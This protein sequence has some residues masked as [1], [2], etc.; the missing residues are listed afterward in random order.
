MYRK[1]TIL[2]AVAAV[3]AVSSYLYLREVPPAPQRE[4]LR[5]SQNV[6]REDK[7][8][9]SDQEA[10]EENINGYDLENDLRITETI[11]ADEENRIESLS[12]QQQYQLLGNISP[13]KM[14]TVL[15]EYKTTLPE[16][17][18]NKVQYFEYHI[19]FDYFLI[20][21]EN[22][23]EI[24]ENPAPDAP[25]VCRVNNM[26][27]VSLLQ[28][29]DGKEFQGSNIWYRV[30][31]SHDNQTEEGYLHSQTGVPRTFRFD[32]MQAGVNQLRQQLAQGELH[33]IRNYKNQ[34]GAPPKKGDAATDEYGYRFYHSAPAY[35]RAD[36]GSNFRYIPD[37]MLVRLLNET[38][39]FYHVN[40]PTFG[41]DYYVPIRYIDKA[42]TL[43]RL[44]HVVV[45]DRNQQNQ[46]A[47]EVGEN[48]L[49][50]ISYTLSTTGMPGDYSFET[51]LGSFKAI[52]KKDRFEYLQKG[53][54]EVGGYAPFAIRF[55]GGAY[56]HGVPVAYQEQGGEKIDPGPIE[57]LQ[58]IGTYPRSNM[59]VRNFTSHARFL[60]NWM[61]SQN[62]AVIVIE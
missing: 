53:S 57:F 33:F 14:N 11:E 18:N 24:R 9:K 7:L 48:G 41:G 62:G 6:P 19:S 47:F 22:G 44:N 45:V 42:V 32:K 55:T 58:T 21:A 56:I 46:A 39:E 31:C 15:Q 51:T 16:G 13:N 36:T 61:D 28:R 23:T 60:Y 54:E 49:N 20:T 8:T 17:I 26:D 52:E 30:A 43:S 25:V 10:V 34:N 59:C 27:K 29:A 35:E 40:V 5:P 4:Q 50:L 12:Q 3:I 1:T 2:I 37:G 38:G